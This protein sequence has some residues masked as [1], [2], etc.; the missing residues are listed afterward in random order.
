MKRL[1]LEGIR[2]ADFTRIQAGP[3]AQAW[4]AHLGAEVIRIESHTAAD[5]LRQMRGA[6]G[7]DRTLNRAPGFYAFSFGKKSCNLNLRHPRAV[8]LAKGIIKTCDVV[9]ENY[10]PGAMER[11]GLDY[12]SLR[13]IKPN[14]IMLSTSGLGQT[15]P[16]AGYAAY[17]ATIHALSGFSS[18][19]GYPGEERPPALMAMMWSDALTATTGAFALLAALHYRKRTG[20][21]QHIDLSMNE[22]TVDFLPEPFLD[23][24]M[25]GRVRGFVGN[26]DEAAA[27]HGVYR[28]QG[29]DKWVAIAVSDD[30]EWQAFCRATGHSEWASDP[31]FADAYSRW[32]HQEELDVLVTQW[33]KKHIP[34]EVTEVLQRAG[35]AAAPSANI[36]DFL[37]DPQLRA[38]NFFMEVEQPPIGKGTAA[39]VPWK[40]G[41]KPDGV[42]KAG[43]NMGEHNHY[44][45]HDILGLSEEEIEKLIKDQVI[46]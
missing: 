29:E 30:Q 39:V 40:L 13:K 20:Q 34:Q 36:V 15:G 44:V 23:Y 11:L 45:F 37:A 31:R 6:A 24:T 19:T 1:P 16:D 17:A 10:A 12:Q 41:P 2:V 27:P 42:R 22:A 33:T 25:N 9:A 28:C 38:R 14:L 5:T 18:L 4:M 32:H 35:V 7:E 8:E 46:Y 21:G 26:R 3:Q 43:P